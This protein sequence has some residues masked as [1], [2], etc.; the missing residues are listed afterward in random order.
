MVRG[1]WRKHRP[2]TGGSDSFKRTWKNAL[3][4]GFIVG[5]AYEQKAP[6]ALQEGWAAQAEQAA[7]KPEELEIAFHLDSAVFDG[8]FANNG[9]LQELPRPLTKLTWDNAALLS[10]ATAESTASPRV[11]AT[12]AASMARRRR[13]NR[14]AI[15][16]PYGGGSGLDPAGHPDDCVT[17]HLGYGRSRAGQ[18]GNSVGFNAYRLRTSTAPWFGRGLRI[19]KTSGVYTL[20][21]TQMHHSMQDRDPVRSGTKTCL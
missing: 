15:R 2:K 16:R 14:I 12:M 13:S 18:V 3:H 7:A 8:R 9:W 19:T 4:D 11:S 20:A 17:I 6:P 10:P 21:C 5:T 1:Y